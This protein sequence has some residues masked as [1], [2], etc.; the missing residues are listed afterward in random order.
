M[1]KVNSVRFFQLHVMDSPVWLVLPW[2]YANIG[3]FNSM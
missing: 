1:S 2:V 3:A